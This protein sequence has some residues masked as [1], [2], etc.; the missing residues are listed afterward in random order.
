MKFS[1]IDF[2]NKSDQISSFLRIWSHLLKKSLMENFIFCAVFLRI[3]TAKNTL[4]K[5]PALTKS[6]DMDI[7]VV[8]IS[9]RRGSYTEIKLLKKFS[10][11]RQNFFLCD[12]SILYSPLYLLYHWLLTEQFCMQLL[13][14]Q[15]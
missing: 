11:Y 1:I 15:F 14:F 8:G 6:M 2:L 4:N 13:G 3:L 12:R 5:T 9:N 7:L 10:S